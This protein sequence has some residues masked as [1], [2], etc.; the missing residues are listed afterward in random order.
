MA[1]PQISTDL[2]DAF[3]WESLYELKLSKQRLREI[4]DDGGV[5][6]VE[7]TTEHQARLALVAD[8][9]VEATKLGPKRLG[10]LARQRLGELKKE[11]EGVVEL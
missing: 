4:L 6:Y 9:L 11:K 7:H 8:L 1:E 2:L 10:E 5:V 3:D